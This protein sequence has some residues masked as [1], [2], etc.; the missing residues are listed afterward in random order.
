MSTLANILLSACLLISAVIHLLPLAG[1]RGRDRLTAL[2]GVPVTEPNL[3]IL[4]RHRAVLFGL[5]GAFL[6]YAAF[7]PSV[8]GLALLAGSISVVSFLV[9]AFAVGPY[10]A[11]LGRIVSADWIALGALVIGVLLYRTM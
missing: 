2:Y 11:Q 10:N 8:Q 5:L 4:L 1:I 3:E 9:L 6:L 7:V